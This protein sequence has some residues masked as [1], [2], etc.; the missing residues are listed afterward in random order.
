V[1]ESGTGLVEPDSLDIKFGRGDPW[2]VMG[3]KSNLAINLR[4]CGE[5]YV[6]VI[7][8]VTV[9]VKSFFLCRAL[10]EIAAILSGQSAV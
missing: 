10:V 9:L 5:G 7:Y 4:S 8:L 6:K 1:A 3:R 2:L